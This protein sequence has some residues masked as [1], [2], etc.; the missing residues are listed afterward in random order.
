MTSITKQ[1]IQ[2]SMD[3]LKE[4][5]APFPSTLFS[6]QILPLC[7]SIML[8]EMYN[9]SPVPPSPSARADVDVNLVNSF[10]KISGS[11]PVPVSDTLTIISPFNLPAYIFIVPFLVYF[12]ELSIKLD[13]FSNPVQITLNIHSSRFRILKISDVYDL[14]FRRIFVLV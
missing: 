13:H 5:V 8:F 12:I 6:A 2:L 10:G 9:P 1:S 4:N 11:M 7:A 14:R 3:K